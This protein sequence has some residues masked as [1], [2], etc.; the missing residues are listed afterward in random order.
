[1]IWL[2]ESPWVS[3]HSLDNCVTTFVLLLLLLLSPLDILPLVASCVTIFVHR[4]HNW[5]DVPSS[6]HPLNHCLHY[7]M[8]IIHSEVWNPLASTSYHEFMDIISSCLTS[9]ILLV[10]HGQLSEILSWTWILQVSSSS[11]QTPSHLTC[12]CNSSTPSCRPGGRGRGWNKR[13][14]LGC[15]PISPNIN[16]QF[17]LTLLHIFLM[18]PVGRICLHMNTLFSFSWLACLIKQWR[19]KE[20]GQNPCLHTTNFLK[21]LFLL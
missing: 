13:R 5:C 9:S 17:L 19:W 15:Y 6:G 16:V 18:E 21:R 11:S 20:K 1:M 8:C 2:T 7:Y 10:F 14:C 4:F 12:N 3:S